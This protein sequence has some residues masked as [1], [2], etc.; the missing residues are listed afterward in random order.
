MSEFIF[1]YPLDL[2]GKL[3]S[4]AVN[5]PI[6]LGTGKVNRSFAFPAGPFY[7]D[8]FKLRSVNSPA[9]PYV[10]GTD[11]ELIFAHTDYEKLSRNQE[12]CMAV[13]V[14]NSKIP[15]D[16][17]VS[18]QVVGGPQSAAVEAIRQAIV[19]LNIDNK[20]V[21]FADLRNF[22][23]T[24]PAAPTFKDIGDLFGFEYIITMLSGILDAIGSGDSTQLENIKAIIDDIK[25]NFLTALLTHANSEGNVHNLNIHQ[26]NGLTETEIR[27]LIAAVQTAIDATI[28]QINAL[29]AADVAINARIDAVVSSL[30]S[31]NDQL[32][33][34][35]Q[36]YQKMVLIVANLNSQ[37]AAFSKQVGDL[38]ELVNNLQ[39]QI[40]ALK[41]EQG[42]TSQL[43]DQLRI[44][45]TALTRRVTTTEQNI[46][47]INQTVSNHLTAADPHTQ[48]LHKQY[49]GVV[50]ANV[51]VNANLTSRDDV[52]AEAGT[53]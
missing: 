5:I 2:T 6:T 38:T 46:G 22:P 33:V 11:Y 16:I 27:A 13:V 23:D 17:T 41:S 44:D 29:K 32:N 48:Y 20:V 14:T 19:S 34:V 47:T 7:A 25:N 36:N 37:V 35:N 8:S 52:Q 1:Q 49:G 42:D 45:L 21:D 30:A 18:A 51:H 15:T 24:L 50:Q 31:F 12:V 3:T 43:I 26:I 10:R 9:T 4:N 53:K 28:T 40:D 39:L